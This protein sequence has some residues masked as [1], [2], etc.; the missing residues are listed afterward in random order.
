MQRLRRVTALS[1]VILA[2]FVNVAAEA[3]NRG[4][5]QALELFDKHREVI[6]KSEKPS[7]YSGY[8]FITVQAKLPE[9]PKMS[10]HDKRRAINSTLGKAL[11]SN[12]T[13]MAEKHCKG[14]GL[15]VK[16]SYPLTIKRGAFQLVLHT[17]HADGTTK[18]YSAQATNLKDALIKSCYT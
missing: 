7:Y 16:K 15:R 10:K 12:L 11:I 8:V 2:Q 14:M 3:E 4:A 17:Q 6:L 13:S 5:L 9:Q 1:G 18:V